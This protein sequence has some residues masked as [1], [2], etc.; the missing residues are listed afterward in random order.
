MTESVKSNCEIFLQ[1]G[2]E[3]AKC[4]IC[5]QDFAGEHLPKGFK[6]ANSCNH[7]FCKECLRG[8]LFSG[9]TNS[10]KCPTCRHVLFD[11]DEGAGDDGRIH[12][13]IPGSEMD[14]EQVARL[15]LELLTCMKSGSQD[16]PED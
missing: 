15:G 9:N 12:L 14:F 7:I 8:W 5:Y 2:I 6:A 4:T 13:T 1:S 16:I 10:N 11:E 3:T